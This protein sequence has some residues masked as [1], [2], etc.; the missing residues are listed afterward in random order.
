MFSRNAEVWRHPLAKPP[1][2][3]GRLLL[4][5]RLPSQHS[6]AIELITM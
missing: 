6:E 2:L 3:F 4:E 5:F 1:F